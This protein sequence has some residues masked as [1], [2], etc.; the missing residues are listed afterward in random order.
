MNAAAW[1]QAVALVCAWL[2]TGALLDAGHEQAEPSNTCAE[3]T[4]NG[5]RK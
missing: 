1:L 5:G 4:T 3:C 2:V